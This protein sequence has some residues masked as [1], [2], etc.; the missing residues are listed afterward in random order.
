[1]EHITQKRAKLKVATVWWE[2]D[3]VVVDM[4]DFG[5]HSK[6]FNER[7][8]LL[9]CYAKRCWTEFIKRVPL[10]SEEENQSTDTSSGFDL[11]SFSLN[12]NFSPA[13]LSSQWE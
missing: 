3:W 6:P 5:R 2:E 13:L 8:V 10:L 11:E 9:V 1:M 12:L 7:I 4:T